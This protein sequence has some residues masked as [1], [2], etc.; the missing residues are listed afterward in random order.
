M[1]F[2]MT[3]NTAIRTAV[4]SALFGL[5]LVGVVHAHDQ[6]AQQ[7]WMN[8]AVC[9]LAVRSASSATRRSDLWPHQKCVNAGDVRRAAAATGM[10]IA[11]R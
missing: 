6:Q 9:L 10:A 5:A 7:T 1:T 8:A 4:P 3:F 2:N 11:R